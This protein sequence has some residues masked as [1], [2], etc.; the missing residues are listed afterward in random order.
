MQDYRAILKE[1]FNL[2]L[3]KN[4]RYTL[5][6]YSKLLELNSG[7]M[8]AVL[9]GQ[10]QL[11]RTHWDLCC[12]K[13]NLSK[14]RK[15][16]FL[17]SLWR[18]FKFQNFDFAENIEKP[19]TTTVADSQ[20]AILSEWEYAAVLCLM[21]LPRF[22]FTPAEIARYLAISLD[23]AKQ[24]YLHLIT[25]QLVQPDTNNT[26]WIKVFDHFKT[27]EDIQSKALMLGHKNEMDLAQIAVEKIPLDRREFSSVTF[28]GSSH[29][30]RKMKIWLRQMKA[31]FDK[32]F[33]KKSGDQVF[34][35][36]MQL[37]PVSQKIKKVATKGRK[38]K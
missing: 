32:K 28:A 18:E 26:G 14:S 3:Q 29:D 35:F 33:E 8:S 20:L 23:R 11:P 12:N 30:M 25:S 9:N 34:L 6:A 16:K 24:I 31:D 5:R 19:K 13:L 38:Q 1:E 7:S 37:F 10:R 22:N 21:D 27:T 4:S 36:S 17:K 2:K 15:E